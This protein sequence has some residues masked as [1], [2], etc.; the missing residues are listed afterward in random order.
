MLSRVKT[1]TDSF[2]HIS[3]NDV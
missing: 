3:M 1:P 2:F